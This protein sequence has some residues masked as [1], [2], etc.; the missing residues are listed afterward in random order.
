MTSGEEFT[1]PMTYVDA[2]SLLID[3]FKLARNIWESG[4]RPNFLVG[5]WR[6]GTPPGVAIHEFFRYNGHD[7]YH[8]AIKTQ[9]YSGIHQSGN[10]EIKG[11]E[12]VID[13]LNSEDKLLLVD[14]VFDTGITMREVLKE[15][16]TRARKNTPE[17]K[18]AT[19]YY[20]PKKNQTDMVPDYYLIENNDWIVF[21]HELQSL[22]KEQIRKKGPE[23]SK[24][25]LGP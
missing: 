18:I 9:S 24:I 7:P 10:V 21:P 8:T 14:D 13:V 22:S 3:S 23:L 20:K 25:I 17:I 5:V 12:H 6:G 2:N 15:I 19:V 4:Y 1:G 16:K 11:L